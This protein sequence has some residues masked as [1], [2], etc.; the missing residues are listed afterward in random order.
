MNRLFKVAG[1]WLQVIILS[2][3]FTFLI[4]TYVAEAREIPSGS[5][6]PT[7]EIGDRVWVDKIYFKF[8]DLDRKDI[9]VFQPPNAP[10]DGI[11]YIKRIIGLPGDT[12]EIR[13]GQVYINNRILSESYLKEPF[14]TNYGP[15]VVPK[16]SYFVMG[17]NRNNSSDSRVWG[18]VPQ[19]NIKGHALFRYFPFNRIGSLDE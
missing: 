2:V 10:K 6:I 9:I 15:I 4:Q 8:S 19:N 3:V 13:K 7:L 14:D 16:D 12:V 17:D 11:P 1:E 5:M 18:F